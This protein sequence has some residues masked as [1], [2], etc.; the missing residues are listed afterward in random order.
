ME[1]MLNFS[2]CFIYHHL[3]FCRITSYFK[4]Q[5]GVSDVIL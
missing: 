5:K 4:E 2:F 3:N 1:I